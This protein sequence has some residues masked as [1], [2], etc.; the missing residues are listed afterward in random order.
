M[1]RGVSWEKAKGKWRATIKRNGTKYSLG[2][3]P[4]EEEEQAAAAYTAISSE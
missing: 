2:Y 3:F 4:A 1:I